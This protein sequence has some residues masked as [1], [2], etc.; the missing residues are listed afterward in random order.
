MFAT[1]PDE[2]HTIQRKSLSAA[3]NEPFG[4]YKTKARS[5]NLFPFRE[6]HRL[7][8]RAT[9]RQGGRLRT[10]TSLRFAPPSTR[11]PSPLRSHRINPRRRRAHAGG[12]C[13]LARLLCAL[14]IRKDSHSPVAV[15]VGTLRHVSS[16]NP[17]LF[18]W[19]PRWAPHSVPQPSID[20]LWMEDNSSSI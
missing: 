2:C 8:M 9:Q 5:R 3:M 12:G 1:L 13:H 19:I 16:I 20:R 7:R 10:R 15:I 18:R 6:L 4:V 11:S 14:I 17:L